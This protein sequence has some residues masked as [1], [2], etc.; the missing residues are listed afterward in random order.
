MKLTKVQEDKVNE[1]VNYFTNSDVNTPIVTFS[2]PTGSGKTFMMAN[3]I[4]KM[5][6]FASEIDT[7][8]MFIIATLSTGEL[9]KQL[10]SNLNEYKQ[11]LENSTFEVSYEESPSVKEASKKDRH[12]KLKPINNKVFIFGKSTFGKNRI[13]TEEEIIESLLEDA[14]NKGYKI[15]YIRDEA[16][17]GVEGLDKTN[18]VSSNDQKFETLL[19]QN[20]NYQ[21]FMTATPKHKEAKKVILTERELL[22]EEPKL[23]K[24]SHFINADIIGDLETLD[25]EQ[26][27]RS[28]CKKFKELIKEYADE[29]REPGLVNINPT[30]L[31]QVKNKNTDHTE[32]FYDQIK[33]IKKVLEEYNL[34]YTHHINDDEEIKKILDNNIL[35]EDNSLKSI[36]KNDSAYQI[37]IFKVGPATGWNNP[38]ANMLVQ[39]RNV[40]SESLNVQTVGR[41]KRNPN[42]A[43][44]HAKDS[45]AYKY[46]IYSNN[47]KIQKNKNIWHLK[48]KIAAL[49]PVVYSGKINAN[50][51][52]EQT[53]SE[54]NIQKV[55]Q[56]I[57]LDNIEQWIAHELKEYQNHWSEIDGI[58]YHF[59]PLVTRDTTTYNEKTNSYEVS[60][61][62]ERKAYNKIELHLFISEI[63]KRYK[64]IL[65]LIDNVKTFEADYQKAIASFNKKQHLIQIDYNFVIFALYKHAFGEIRKIIHSNIETKKATDDIT[66]IYKLSETRIT[67]EYEVLDENWQEQANNSSSK[68]RFIN[69]SKFDNY[70]YESELSDNIVLDSKT[71]MQT[72]NKII[73]SLDQEQY[74]KDVSFWYKNSV[75]Q[76]VNL[77][78]FDKDDLLKNSYPDLV[79]KYKNKHTILMEIKS[80]DNDYDPEKTQKLLEN[81]QSYIKAYNVKLSQTLVNTSHDKSVTLIII[82]QKSASNKFTFE[83][84]S[85]NELLNKAL[86][87]NQIN[88]LKDILKIL[89]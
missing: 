42:P 11:Y 56:L 78:I 48:E 77:Q 25:N 68:D 46:F 2:A 20:A 10:E 55:T 32:D 59:L 66:K 38:R 81:Y 89:K 57:N 60:T 80:L 86:E 17:V 9:P 47:P 26:L 64:E 12:N 51:L 69:V 63:S 82:K 85:T 21:L 8:I 23:L 34:V 33:L 83:G 84:A 40:S 72:L 37:I 35:R 3:I 6:S 53:N 14:Q 73:K 15:V 54:N 52:E 76:G 65:N 71:E 79:C 49:K 74:K 18:K 70:A 41:I 24:S 4:D 16:H 62:I 61:Y 45:V 44:K 5:I 75:Y 43:F 36:S 27:L 28:A 67:D 19:A 58:K 88:D 22:D 7:P 39:L 30:M 29:T 50:Y 13:Y 87:S 31:I 1:I